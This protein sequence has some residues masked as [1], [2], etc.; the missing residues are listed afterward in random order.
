MLY[1]QSWQNVFKTSTKKICFILDWTKMESVFPHTRASLVFESDHLGME[2]TV[3]V[4]QRSPPP[5]T[6]TTTVTTTQNQGQHM[7]MG[8]FRCSSAPTCHYKGSKY[9]AAGR[10]EAGSAASDDHVKLLWPSRSRRVSPPPP[11][12]S[13][14]SASL[15]VGGQ[16]LD[17][18]TH[19]WM[20]FFFVVL[21]ELYWNEILLIGEILPNKPAKD[22]LK[23][24]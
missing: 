21:R 12:P 2:R 20:F 13:S 15:S 11:P 7:Y 1:I 14:S 23:Y 18:N 10:V 4:S 24:L 17:R 5:T 6:T 16:T 19:W 8:L 22:I 9:L 3:L